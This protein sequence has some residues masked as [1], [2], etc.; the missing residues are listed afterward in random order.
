[1]GP[2]RGLEYCE[3]LNLLVGTKNKK[4]S[5]INDLLAFGAI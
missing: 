1:M 3:N 2:N 4:A 5:K